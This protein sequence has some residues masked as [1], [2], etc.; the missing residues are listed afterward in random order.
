LIVPGTNER[1]TTSS[2]SDVSSRVCQAVSSMKRVATGRQNTKPASRNA[3]FACDCAAP[4]LDSGM[5]PEPS[6]RR[7]TW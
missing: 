6:L 1:A 5:P 4:I 7:I 3:K 2:I